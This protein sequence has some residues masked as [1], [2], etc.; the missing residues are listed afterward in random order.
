MNLHL[1]GVSC[2]GKGEM[3]ASLQ[4]DAIWR[5][6]RL[7][8]KRTARAKSLRGNPYARTLRALKV[9]ACESERLTCS[10]LSSHSFL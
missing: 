9:Y 5:E 4:S 7:M 8:P 2:L 6:R 1:C 10:A 3:R